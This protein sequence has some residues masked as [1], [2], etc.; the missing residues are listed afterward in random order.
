[1]VGNDNDIC[2]KLCKVDYKINDFVVKFN[3]RTF[4]TIIYVNA[5]IYAHISIEHCY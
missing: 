2:I 3:K 1:M 4:I 5:N